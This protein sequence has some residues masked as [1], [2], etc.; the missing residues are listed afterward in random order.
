MTQS[1]ESPPVETN[2]SPIPHEREENTLRP[3]SPSS[4]GSDNDG[5]ER[6]V[7]EKF[8][9]ASIAG[10]SERAAAE[11]NPIAEKTDTEPPLIDTGKAEDKATQ[12]DAAASRGRPTRK[13]SF[14]DL[15]NDSPA[16]PDGKASEN[17]T[18]RGNH[19]RMRS[20]DISGKSDHSDGKTA[21]ELVEAVA[22]EE[23]DELAR[24]SPG[25]A[26]VMV[27]APSEEDGSS[28]E[29][30]SPKKKRSRDQFDKDQSPVESGSGEDNEKDDVIKEDKPTNDE[31]TMAPSAQANTKGEPEKKRPRDEIPELSKGEDKEETQATVGSKHLIYGSANSCPMQ[32]A[33]PAG[34][35]ATTTPFGTLPQPKSPAPKPDMSTDKLPQTSSSA[36]ASSGLAAF[37]TKSAFGALNRSGTSTGFGSFGAKSSTGGFG[38]AP[39]FGGTTSFGASGTTGF[40]GLGATSGFGGL[41]GSTFGGSSLGLS[42]FATP[43]GVK[44]KPLGSLSPTKAPGK[45]DDDGDED[46]EAGGI[47]DAEDDKDPKDSR[48]YAQQSEF[49]LLGFCHL[50]LLT[51]SLNSGNRRRRRGDSLPLSC[52]TILFRKGMEGARSW[53][54]EA[55]S[56]I[57]TIQ[58]R[59]H[60]RWS[61]L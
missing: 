58:R 35:D 4:G 31:L 2:G 27:E 10:L 16:T 12:A 57:H 21:K 24:L 5:G 54:L 52:Q 14:D 37:A 17:A 1:A 50:L 29:D 25:G 23:D 19:K 22:E 40:G 34:T 28:T 41:G 39:G 30:K 13:R 11:E 61:R 49:R 7:R 53:Y 3:I 15:Q 8:K 45:S 47:L 55:Q 56:S 38:S 59:R 43:G 20:R 33:K 42:S 44:S 26:G 36:F 6:P 46:S 18:N 60:K 51:A 9:K 32:D 48:F